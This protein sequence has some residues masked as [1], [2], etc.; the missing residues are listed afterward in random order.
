MNHPEVRF[1][2]NEDIDF[3]KWDRCIANSIYG[4]VYAY[5]WY[6]DL[7]CERW[8][9]LIWGDYLYIMPLVNK[10]KFG[11]N[12]IYQPFFTQQLGIFSGFPTDPEI[13]NLFIASIPPKFKLIDYKLNSGNLPTSSKLQF[14]QNSNYQLSLDSSAAQIQRN[15][16]TN[17]KR[18]IKKAIQ[19]KVQISRVYDNRAFIQFTRENLKNKSPEIKEVNYQ[20]LFKLVSHV[21]YH[22]KGEIYGAYDASN[23]LIA[24]AFFLRFGQQCIYL[25]ASSTEAGTAQSAMFLLV[26]T[27]I[28]N[29][30][31]KQSMLDFEGS[32]I[33]G[34]ARF[35]SGFGATHQIYYSFHQNRLSQLLRLFKK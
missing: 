2:K 19:E 1:V 34:I 6:L 32:N 21:L 23:N 18:N 9:A 25:V 33:A 26:D 14:Q 30:S 4:T 24:A 10:R 7:V 16:S 15:Y 31:Q 22:Q 27:Y 11:I 3:Q 17:T 29:N 28:V 5:S 35:Y 20:A 13:V 12:Y 8:D